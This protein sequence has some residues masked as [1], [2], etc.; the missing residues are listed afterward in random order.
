LKNNEENYYIFVNQTWKQIEGMFGGITT[1]SF[2]YH[3]NQVPFNWMYYENEIK[4]LFVG[5]LIG[6]G[7]FG[8]LNRILNSFI[9]LFNC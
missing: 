4:M 3:M 6:I 7:Y 5:G 9:W 8:I 2:D 1:D